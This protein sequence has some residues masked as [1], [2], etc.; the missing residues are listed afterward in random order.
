MLEEALSQPWR[1]DLSAL[2]E[3]ADLD[4]DAMLGRQATLITVLADGSEQRRTGLVAQAASEDSDGGL[5]R[6]RLT[7]QPWLGF[8]SQSFRSIT[9]QEKSVTAIVDDVLSRYADLGRWRW[10]PCVGTLLADAP[11]GGVRS[12]CVQYRESD[13]DFIS[14]LLAEEGIGYRFEEA[15]RG[16]LGPT[17]VF[18]A[19]STSAQSLPEDAASAS[20]AGGAGIRF[21]ADGVQEAQDTVQAFGGVRGQP[22]AVLSAVSFDYQTGRVIGAEVPTLGSVGGDNALWLEAYDSTQGYAFADT[23]Q[24]ERALRLKQQA[25]EA[26]HKHWIGRGVVRSFSAGSTFCLAESMLDGLDALRASPDDDKRFLLTRVTHVG[27]NNLPKEASGSIAGEAADADGAA[28]S[29][30]LPPS[31]DPALRS[32]AAKRGY[33]NRFEAI[34]AKVPWRPLLADGTGARLKAKPRVA[35]PLLGLTPIPRTV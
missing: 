35:G 17:V 24:A 16:D 26:R 22:V 23:A 14:R 19:D 30:A 33:A 12:Y 27:V 20:S 9:W 18:F 11:Q 4:L 32:Q 15:E 13:L 3:R 2:H 8:L 7:V 5:A 1:L 6:Y 34:R 31:I 21:H 10:S 29:S 25:L 28:S